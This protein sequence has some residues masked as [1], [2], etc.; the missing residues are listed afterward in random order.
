M[1]PLLDTPTSPPGNSRAATPPRLDAVPIERALALCAALLL[2]AGLI[3][4]VAANWQ[5][6]TRQ[7]KYHLLQSAVLAPALFAVW[8]PARLPCLLLA[9]L[10]LGG[11]LAFVGQTYQTGADPWQLFAVWAALSLVWTVLSRHDVLWTVW[12][13]ICGTA[14]GLWSGGHLLSAFARPWSFMGIDTFASLAWLL[15]AAL[16]FALTRFAL[17]GPTR[18]PRPAVFSQRLATWMALGAWST[19]ALWA[20]MG[21]DETFVGTYFFNAALIGMTAYIAWASRPRDIVVLA[22]SALAFDA[23]FLATVFKFM[24]LNSSFDDPVGLVLL[25]TLIAAGTVG[26]SSLWVFRQ[27][28]QANKE[29]PQ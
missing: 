3:F 21:H 20:L 27:Q 26:G 2:G 25:F 12:V 24:F 22:G 16:P 7:F 15:L 17:L 23:V 18:A 8:R 1:P 4:W 5:E 11:L 6:Q 13:L 14:I 19:Y 29:I 10:S 9:T 28:R